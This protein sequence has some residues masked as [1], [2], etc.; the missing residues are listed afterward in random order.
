[1]LVMGQLDR[2]FLVEREVGLLV[3]IPRNVDM[4]SFYVDMRNG[5][6]NDFLYSNIML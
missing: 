2:E 3:I 6:E 5:Y 1:M 4:K